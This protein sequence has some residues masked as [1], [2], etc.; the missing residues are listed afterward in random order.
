MPESV[1]RMKGMWDAAEHTLKT[2]FLMRTPFL[3]SLSEHC[4]HLSW[5]LL[6]RKLAPLE[7]DKEVAKRFVNYDDFLAVPHIG[8]LLCE[9]GRE[10]LLNWPDEGEEGAAEL[11]ADYDSAVRVVQQVERLLPQWRKEWNKLST[12]KRITWQPVFKSVKELESEALRQDNPYIDLTPRARMVLEQ[13]NAKLSSPK[14][15]AARKAERTKSNVKLLSS[16][17][18]SKVEKLR[19]APKAGDG[20]ADPPLSTSM[21]GATGD[22]KDVVEPPSKQAAEPPS[23][24]ETTPPREKAATCDDDGDAV[25]ATIRRSFCR[26]VNNAEGVIESDE[27]VLQLVTKLAVEL[28]L[29]V[30]PGELDAKLQ[31]AAAT[32]WDQASFESWF[33][34]NIYE[35]AS[36]STGEDGAATPA[37]GA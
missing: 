29:R 20:E 1:S 32:R 17:I 22:A 7:A 12:D 8:L 9:L 27:E 25:A 19:V 33:R 21:N 18:A 3:Q 6:Q 2:G 35:T 37:A 31:V 15:F 34:Q 26:Y 36:H 23:D 28:K 24:V 4:G 13:S 11:R 30:K 14:S 10:E 16:V 5:A